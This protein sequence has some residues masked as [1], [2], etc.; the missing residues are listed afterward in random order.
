MGADLQ[1]AHFIAI[2]ENSFDAIISKD[3]HGTV[4]SWNPAAHR[5]F[6]WSPDEIV[7]RSIRIIIP[8]DLNEEEDRI[9]ARI[10]AGD[11]VPKFETVRLHKSGKRVPVAVTVSPIF[12][13]VGDIVGASKIASDIAAI[14]ELHARLDAS[15]RQFRMLANNIPQLAWIADRMARFSGTTIAGMRIRARR[16]KDARLGLDSAHHP[17][18]VERVKA[19]IQRSLGYRRWNGKTP[20]RCEVET[21]VIVGSCRARSRCWM[22]TEKVWRWFGTNTDVTVQR[23]NEERNPA[24]DGRGQSPR[25]EYDRHRPGGGVK[26]S[27]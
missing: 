27:G 1:N 24:L 3:L 21:A 10:G 17:D 20:F 22:T 2:V 11:H 16:W 13:S 9:L 19:R 12:N 15:E 5:I 25:E 14:A 8:P 18:H 4:Q 26:D 6:G 7:G 23:E